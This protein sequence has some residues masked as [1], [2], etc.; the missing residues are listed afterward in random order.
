MQ[1][2]AYCP[3]VPVRPGLSNGIFLPAEGHRPWLYELL[4]ISFSTELGDCF[5]TLSDVPKI[6]WGWVDHKSESLMGSR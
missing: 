5:N 3:E 2:K 4:T 6:A 1:R